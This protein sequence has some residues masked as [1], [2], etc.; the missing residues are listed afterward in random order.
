M[1]GQPAPDA[2]VAEV[3]LRRLRHESGIRNGISR[4]L[5]SATPAPVPPASQPRASER[6]P[7]MHGVTTALSDSSTMST[8]H[9]RREGRAAPPMRASSAPSHGCRPQSGAGGRCHCGPSTRSSRW[10]RW[11]APPPPRRRCPP[12]LAA[13]HSRSPR[14]G[15]P[16]LPRPLAATPPPP[17]WH[18]PL[19]R[20]CRGLPHHSCVHVRSVAARQARAS[21]FRA[22]AAA[23]L[24]A[25]LAA[26]S[27][28]CCLLPTRFPCCQRPGS[29]E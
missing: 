26:A 25:A 15:A 8:R 12:C 29:W 14:R 27:G 19:L 28:G 2:V 3:V 24:L 18:Q 16:L 4:V 17:L 11:A 20:L 5:S 10:D 13:A 6:A 21:A 23:P 7:T 22:P 1:V 9:C